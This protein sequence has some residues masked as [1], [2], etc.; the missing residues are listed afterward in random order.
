MYQIVIRKVAGEFWNYP[1][2]DFNTLVLDT[3][4]SDAI[5]NEF[6]DVGLFVNGHYCQE[7]FQG[8]G[9]WAG[10]VESPRTFVPELER[11]GGGINKGS[12]RPSLSLALFLV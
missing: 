6:L 1:H 10:N 12:F 8:V 7:I 2:N 3:Q 5:F 4:V 11:G 9:H